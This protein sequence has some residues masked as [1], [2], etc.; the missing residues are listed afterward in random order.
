MKL[1]DLKLTLHLEYFLVKWSKLGFSKKAHHLAR[2][3]LWKKRHAGAGGSTPTLDIS[4]M[5]DMLGSLPKLQCVRLYC[6]YEV[7]DYLGPPLDGQFNTLA[8][9][10]EANLKSSIEAIIPGVDAAVAVNKS[11]AKIN[12][13]A[14]L[15]VSSSWG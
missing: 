4:G 1:R 2:A 12:G 14:S 5:L 13:T 6:I 9:S 11:H 15:P 7:T 8:S 10:L 3:S